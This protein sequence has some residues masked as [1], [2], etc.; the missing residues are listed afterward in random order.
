MT[1]KLAIL[2]LGYVGS[3]LAQLFLSNENFVSGFDPSP[4]AR[5]LAEARLAEYGNNFVTG[6]SISRDSSH[7][8]A[9]IICVPTP[10]TS[11]GRPDLSYIRGSVADIAE[12]LLG[13]PKCRPLIVLESTTYPGCTRN[14]VAEAI[15][16][17]SGRKCGED[18]FVAYSPERIDPGSDRQISS[19]PK[20]VGGF[21]ERSLSLAQQLYAS[22]FDEVHVTTSLEDA[23]MA[24]LLENT[25][26]YLNICFINEVSS[27]A[28]SVGVNIHEAIKAAATKPFG[29]MAFNPGPGVGGHCIPEDPQYLLW[30]LK[31]ASGRALK[32]V[33]AAN[34]ISKEIPSHVLERVLSAVRGVR[35]EK[36][37][38]LIL[39]L[40]YKP[41]VGDTRNAPSQELISRLAEIAVVAACD[42]HVPASKWPPNVEKVEVHDLNLHISKS[43]LTVLMTA[44]DE[45]RFLATQNFGSPILDTTG[46]IPSQPLVSKLY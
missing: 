40:S 38:I 33:E 6:E 37:E 36:P 43:S 44:H 3:P 8:D 26:R 28:G 35:E 14:D 12:Y 1:Y 32:S 9:V 31:A 18:F 23:E 29:F 34:A 20:V 4:E 15:E 5:S 16:K 19:V 24:K 21:D 30:S 2:G 13:N 42:P 10:T 25:F 45:F 39:G 46:L 7:Y 17:T 11:A 22:V 27:L 41:N